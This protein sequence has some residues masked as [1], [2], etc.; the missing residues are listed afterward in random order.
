QHMVRQAIA[1]A[2][3][4]GIPSPVHMRQVEGPDGAQGAALLDEFSNRSEAPHIDTEDVF[5]TRE[6]TADVLRRPHAAF[7]KGFVYLLPQRRMIPGEIRKM[8]QEIRADALAVRVEGKKLH[9]ARIDAA[10]RFPRSRRQ[11]GN[12]PVM[13]LGPARDRDALAPITL[14]N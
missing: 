13:P 6:E 7:E 2:R 10:K 1:M 5:T 12:R 9:P 8:H 14:E 11:T 4:V 3:L